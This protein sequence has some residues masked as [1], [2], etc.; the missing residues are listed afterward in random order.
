MKTTISWAARM[1]ALPEDERAAERA[2]AA[3]ASR[4]SKA[5]AR[6][7]TP[8]K[9]TVERLDAKL[10]KIDQQLADLKDQK[11]ALAVELK[12]AKAA[13]AQAEKNMVTTEGEASDAAAA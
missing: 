4:R 12:A 3:E 7:T 11:T 6:G 5:K 9:R 13:M 1:A 2:K 10:A 8:E